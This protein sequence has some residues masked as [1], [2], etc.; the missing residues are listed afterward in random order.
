MVYMT[1]LTPSKGTTVPYLYNSLAGACAQ[2]V[3]LAAANPEGVANVAILEYAKQFLR[4]T[5]AQETL[6]QEYVWGDCCPN[7]GNI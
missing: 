2:I 7:I 6:R 3:T 4:N 5:I 1:T